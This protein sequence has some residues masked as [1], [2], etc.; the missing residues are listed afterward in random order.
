[1][2]WYCDLSKSN[3]EIHVRRLN[4]SINILEKGSNG[5]KLDDRGNEKKDIVE[6]QAF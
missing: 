5:L 3:C 2:D 6:S 4:S 1:M